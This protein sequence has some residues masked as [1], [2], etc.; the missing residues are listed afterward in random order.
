[1]SLQGGA[2]MLTSRHQKKPSA[3]HKSS[4][5]KGKPRATKLHYRKI[6]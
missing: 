1:M 2:G 5:V 3:A 6:K 4:G